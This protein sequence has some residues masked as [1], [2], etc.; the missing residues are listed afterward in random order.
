MALAA[1][2][3]T[4]DVLQQVVRDPRFRPLME[5]PVFDAVPIALIVGAYTA[6]GISSYLYL[7][8]DLP[9][10]AAL[11][12]NAIAIYVA[13][14]PLHDATHRTVS[15]DGTV[16]DLLGTISGFA[17]VPGFTT[18][19]YRYLHLEHHRFAGD[20]TRDPDDP[21]VSTHPLMLP[22]VLAAPDIL[23]SIW[24]WRHRKT[25]PLSEQ[26][27]A[28]SILVFYL[29]FHAV[30]LAS[31]YAMEFILLWMIPQRIGLALVTY[32]FAHIQHPEGVQWEEA[33]FQTTVAIPSNRLVRYFMLGQTEHYIH[34]LFPSIP[35][36]RYHNAFELGRTL[37]ET[38]DIPERGLFSPARDI[39]LPSHDGAAVRRARIVRVRDV[40]TDVKSFELMPVGLGQLPEFEAGAHIDVHM[41]AGMVRQYSLCNPPHDQDRYVIAV[42]KDANG[43][44]GS[45]YMHEHVHAGEI[46]AIG[47]PRNNFRL[48][49]SS[50]RVVLVSGGIG[51]TPLLSMAHALHQE[52]RF[53]ELHVCAR[54][55]ASVPFAKDLSALPFSRAISVH[56]DHDGKPTMPIKETLGSWS[57][58]DALYVCG[59]A[60]FMAAIIGAARDLGW[61]DS[62][63]RSEAFTPQETDRSTNRPFIV[64]LARSGKTLTVG[65]DEYLLD[66]LTRNK[67]TVAYS[68]TQGIC[69]SCIT[70]V[71][72]G[73]PEHRD[74]I[75]S[76]DERAS[77]TKMC[78]CVSRARGERIVL[79]L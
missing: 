57:D 17:L 6:F 38:L 8:G 51:V 49:G 50:R 11:A 3:S 48:P 16:N 19:L 55:E 2:A 56:L 45:S 47:A 29:G 60:P 22:F 37:F 69:G 27:E 65:A 32:F 46:V 28:L 75:L 35:H 34:H 12:I 61:P 71:L 1:T 63:I 30:F 7:Q 15:G 52:K 68:C 10:L 74:A 26:I 36:Y 5:I 76:E 44:G 24:Y 73:T 66:V 78:V 67:V 33:P 54:D 21:L 43:R 40:A 14:T 31:P 72:A 13:F 77:N 53:F 42:K 23:W 25:R 58:G 41:A 64:E 59:P 4:R 18:R 9:L 39:T 79:D 70:G 20:K 62:A